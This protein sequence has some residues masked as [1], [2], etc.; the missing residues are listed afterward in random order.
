MAGK[1]GGAW[2][3]AYAD[4]VTAMMA[5]FLVMWITAQSDQMKE[6]IANHFNDPFAR[7]SEEDGA[8]HQ[9]PPRH[10]SPARITDRP[11]HE[12]EAGGSH[13]G[14]LTTR[15]RARTTPGPR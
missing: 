11:Q 5:F 13:S 4:F 12:K 14:V 10:P 7:E 8:A 9:H 1:H 3:V 2:K 6:A 15:G